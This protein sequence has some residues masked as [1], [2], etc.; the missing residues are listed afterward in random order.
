MVF[1][2]SLMENHRG[3]EF[4]I[5]CG[6]IGEERDADMGWAAGV[7]CSESEHRTALC[8]GLANI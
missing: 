5:A 6:R 3:D 1:W 2:S 8:A 4:G 7:Q